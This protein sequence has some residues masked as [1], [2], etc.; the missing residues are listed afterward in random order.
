[1][2][3]TDGNGANEAITSSGVSVLDS[4]SG[5]TNQVDAEGP[6]LTSFSIRDATLEVG[7]TVYIDYLFAD[8]SPLDRIYFYF[9]DENGNWHG[10]EDRSNFGGIDG[11]AELGITSGM[12]SGSYSINQV[13]A[14]DQSDLDNQSIHYASGNLS[15]DVSS[16]THSLDLSTLNFTVAGRDSETAESIG[17]ISA[18][19][20]G[21]GSDVV[22]NFY[23]DSDVVGTSVNSFDAVVRFD[24]TGAEYASAEFGD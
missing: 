8:A 20:A 2:S 5:S 22:L 7:E 11:T 13:V 14:F 15:G 21:S 19:N 17:A 24:A 9:T 18:I 4:E 1:M 16:E 10:A 23:A 3:Y 6:I 12:L